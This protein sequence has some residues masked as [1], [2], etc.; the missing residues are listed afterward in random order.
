M[1]LLME[2]LSTP[3]G[4]S[5]SRRVS[6]LFF[7]ARNTERAAKP[8]TPTIA[9][10]DCYAARDA[11]ARA[12]ENAAPEC[13][14]QAWHSPACTPPSAAAT[15]TP[16]ASPAPPSACGASLAALPRAPLSP[17]PNGMDTLA[18][19]GA[20]PRPFAAAERP[21]DFS[22]SGVCADVDLSSP[23]PSFAVRDCNEVSLTPF[24][25][26]VGAEE[27]GTRVL[28]AC[29]ECGATLTLH[30]RAGASPA[31]DVAECYTPTLVDPSAESPTVK[32]ASRRLSAST[33]LLMVRPAAACSP[34]HLQCALTAAS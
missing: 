27:L 12:D 6:P 21:Q 11:V 7:H 19:V 33:D 25:S 28:A 29:L 14:A 23:L 24:A 15:C 13:S 32:A 4:A 30:S 2:S 22:F 9:E 17:L 3:R 5:G 10:E 20:T 18:L 34:A 8:R 1:V 16:G 26:P 31:T